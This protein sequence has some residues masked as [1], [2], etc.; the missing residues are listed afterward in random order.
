MSTARTASPPASRRRRL[1]AGLA[2][3][4]VGV[5][6]CGGGDDDGPSGLGRACRNVERLLEAVSV[7]DRDLAN[8]ELDRLTD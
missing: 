6:A 1:A 4:L 7:G 5:T 2:A 3:L 8:D